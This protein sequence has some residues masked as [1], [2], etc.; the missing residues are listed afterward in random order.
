[1]EQ[2]TREGHFA[3]A[4]MNPLVGETKSDDVD[5]A[6]RMMTYRALIDNKVLGQGDADEEL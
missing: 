6:T 1:M 2:L 5:E 4:V 3:G